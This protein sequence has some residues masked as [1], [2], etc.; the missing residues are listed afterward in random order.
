MNEQSRTN[1]ETSTNHE[2]STHHGPSTHGPST[3]ETGSQPPVPSSRGPLDRWTSRRTL[4]LVILA[5]S[6]LLLLSTTQTWVTASGL[7]ETATVDEVA[8]T[9]A[10]AAETVT[11]MG[12]VGLAS[13]LA[14]T[15]ARKLIR[16]LIAVLVLASS[17]VSGAAV[18]AVLSDPAAA[19]TAAL[20]ETT[21][22]TTDAQDYAL[23]PSLWLAAVAVVLVTLA[24]LALLLVSHR[25]PD[26]AGRRY[27]SPAEGATAAAAEDLDEFDLWDDLS[28]GEDPTERP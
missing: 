2:T 5:A 21:G 6:A 27:E 12:L 16:Y 10:E 15:I 23:S 26:R 11:A 19:V 22:T 7:G 18:V 13:A 8:I 4:V 9:G 3:H 20:G 28:Q 1:D 17:A 24:G 25:W 14:L